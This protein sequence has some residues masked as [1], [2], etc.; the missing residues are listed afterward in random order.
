[1]S[2]ATTPAGA[3]RMGLVMAVGSALAYG[4]NIVGVQLSGLSGI[5]G[6]LII[7]YR[8][9]LMLAGLALVIALW[10]VPIA[11][12]ALHRRPLV[13]LGVMSALV[14]S[15]YLSSVAFLPVSVAVVIFYT[16]PVIVVLAE[17]FVS[18][19]RFGA[20]RLLL[21]LVA[22]TGVALVIGPNFSSLDPRGVILASIASLAAAFQFFAAARCANVPEVPKLFWVNVMVAPVAVVILMVTGGFRPP[23]ALMV[24]PIAASVAIGGFVF[25]LVLQFAALSRIAAGPAALA[26]CLEPVAA[27]S[28]AALILGERML[29]LQYVGVALVMGAVAANVVREQRLAR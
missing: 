17:P 2:I 4:I 26:F 11:V 16:F 20:A 18:G 13:L 3:V 24:T 28:F 14:G 12:A 23:S 27:S 21:A 19:T 10:R 22:F 9:A 29:P 15:A 7:F 6:P 8:T 5:S 1:M 25:G